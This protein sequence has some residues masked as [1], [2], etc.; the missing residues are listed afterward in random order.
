M[1]FAH[2]WVIATVQCECVSS[3]GGART[4]L[5]EGR[6][7]VSDLHGAEVGLVTQ[8]EQLGDNLTVSN[9]GFTPAFSCAQREA[10]DFTAEFGVIPFLTAVICTSARKWQDASVGLTGGREH[11]VHARLL[12]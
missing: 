7:F 1:S 11:C 4:G 9:V 5:G 10:G 8:S 3:S 12:Q 2:L 6:G